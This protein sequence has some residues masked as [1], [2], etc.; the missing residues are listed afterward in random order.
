MKYIL[1]F[2]IL[3][4]LFIF[5]GCILG[6]Q[7][8]W[9]GTYSYSRIDEGLPSQGKLSDKFY[10]KNK[11]ECLDWGDKKLKNE[12]NWSYICRYNYEEVIKSSY[13]L[14]AETGRIK[15]LECEEEIRV[16]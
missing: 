11:Q 2:A 15:S 9:T 8:R 3:F 14:G 5:S 10:F 4:S 1:L 13:D 16:P 6:N 7:N 12:N